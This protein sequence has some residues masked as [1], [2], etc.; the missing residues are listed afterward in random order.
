MIWQQT[1]ERLGKMKMYGIIR[2]LEEQE[3]NESY[4]GMG[5]EDRLGHAVEREYLERENRRLSRRIKSARLRQQACVEDIKFGIGRNLNKTKILDLAKCEWVKRHQNIIITGP[6]GAGKSYLACALGHSA[7]LNGYTVQYARVSRFLMELAVG[8]G[9]GSYEKMMKSV[10]R[11]ELLLLDDF[12]LAALGTEARQD[13]LEV[14][15]DRHEVRSTI[16]VSQLPVDKW[17]DIVGNSTVA[18]AILDRVVHG[19]HRIN[20]QASD[21]M[22]KRKIEA[23]EVKKEV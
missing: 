8:R 14:V 2:A 16:I 22:R 13:L 5:F 11:S 12:G 20:L 7:C 15:E 10:L 1:L 19:S 6:T 9:D 17:H 3:S 23:R 21:S 4:G 18:D